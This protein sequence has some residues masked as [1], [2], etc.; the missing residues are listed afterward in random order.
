VSHLGRILIVDDEPKI[1]SF[2]GRA[3][4][5]AGY[6]TDFSGNGADAVTSAL[7][8]RYDLVILDLVMPDLDGRQVLGKPRIT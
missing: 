4:A 6:A 3:L 2:I 8:T 5:T 7:K 1:R